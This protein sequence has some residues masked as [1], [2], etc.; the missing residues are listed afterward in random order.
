M[1]NNSIGNLWLNKKQVFYY[2]AK[3]YYA[4]TLCYHFHF[5]SISEK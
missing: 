2:T 4:K 1:K 3:Q 5:Y